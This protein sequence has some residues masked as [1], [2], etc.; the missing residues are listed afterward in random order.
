M[1]TNTQ[2]SSNRSA[3]KGAKPVKTEAGAILIKKACEHTT[4]P[5]FKCDRSMRVNGIEI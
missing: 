2:D 3:W 4:C 5:H 1:Q